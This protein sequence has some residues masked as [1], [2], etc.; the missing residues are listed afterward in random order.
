[1]QWMINAYLSFV[2]GV[3]S[4]AFQFWYDISMESIKIAMNKRAK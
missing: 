4:W 2:K 1:M 3:F